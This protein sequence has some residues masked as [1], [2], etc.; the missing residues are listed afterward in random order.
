MRHYQAIAVLAFAILTRCAYSQTSFRSSVQ[1]AEVKHGWQ[2]REASE[3]TWHPASVPGCVHTDLMN[4]HLIPDPYVGINE[5]QLQ[6]IGEKNWI[7]QTTFDVPAGVLGCDSVELV[8]KGLDT[9]A[10]VFLNDSLLLTADNM[11]RE[12]RRECKSRLKVK[13]NSLSITFR[14]VFDE[15]LPKYRAAPYRLSAYDNNDQA[16]VKI[17]MYSR[18]AQFHYGWDWGPRLITCGLWRPVVLEG[19]SAVR[20]RNVR[21]VQQEVSATRAVLSSVFQLQLAKPQHVAIS[22]SADGLPLGRLDTTLGAGVSSITLTGILSDPNLWW[23]NGLG[24]QYLYTYTATV[25]AGNGIHDAYTTKLGVRSLEVVRDR[26]SLG[27]SLYI[28]LNGVP[29]FMKGADYI[30]QDNFQNRV[31]PERHEFMIRSAATANMNMLRIWGGGIFEDDQFYD[32]CDRYGILLWHDLMFACAMYPADEAFLS[33]VREEIIENVC[34]LRNHACIALWCGNNENDI[35]W[36]G[37]GWKQQY[38]RE[39][40]AA[41]ER[42]MKKLAVDVV[43]RAVQEA[44]PGRYFHASSPLAGYGDV[45]PMEGDIHYWGVWHGKEP[46]EFFEKNIARF[47]TEYGF[48]SYPLLPTVEKYAAAA[49]RA[50][51]SPVMLSHQRCMSDGRRDKEY[52]NR[53]IAAYMDR[54]FR[55]PKD[56]PSYI[57]VSQVLQAEGV[58]MAIEAHR[59][60]M[61]VCMGSLY[62]QLDDCW[63]VA[64]WSSIDYYGEWKALHY[65]A[66][67]LYEPVILVPRTAG[68]TV[69]VTAVS[70]RLTPARGDLVVRVVDFDGTEKFSGTYPVTVNANASTRCIHLKKGELIA[71][72]DE[73]RLVMVLELRSGDSVLS[74]DLSYFTFP[75]DLQLSKA[76]ISVRSEKTIKGYRLSLTTNTL[77]KDVYLSIE[78]TPSVFSDNFFDL[79]PGTEK[80][81]EVVPGSAVQD[82]GRR[83]KVMSLYDSYEEA[84]QRQ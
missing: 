71:G 67:R 40:Q 8:F 74:Q 5:Q 47:V 50:L 62:W 49:D 33:N 54:M 16:D 72:R 57:Y 60:N 81:V 32:L 9:Y 28:R 66:K 24:S 43:L 46:F 35:S 61:P 1:R 17:A 82:I 10:T 27:R 77:A 26:D 73:R 15:N 41:Y 19:W 48:Q 53:L 3:Q 80:T 38:P 18:K 45:S 78:G 56:F 44:D 25:N 30:P 34:R 75:K 51:H 13:G 63:P 11:F 59:R 70:D 79:L 68:D 6:W 31:T 21:I 4:D 2:F 37:W 22:A 20:I 7:Y 23:T 65:Y 58:K 76:D 69:S 83:L 12:W 14:N 52:G 39:T 29:V 84:G 55:S 42:D 36:F 64:S